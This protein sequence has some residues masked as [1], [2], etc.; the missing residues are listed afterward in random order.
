[1]EE[2]LAMAAICIMIGFFTVVLVLFGLGGAFIYKATVASKNTNHKYKKNKFTPIQRSTDPAILQP[3]PSPMAMLRIIP[4]QNVNPHTSPESIL[5]SNSKIISL[6][7]ELLTIP[8]K[9][10]KENAEL[11]KAVRAE[12][13]KNI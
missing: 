12:I 3:Q 13:K 5:H 11:L 4:I 1:M 2:S 7:E 8:D 9:L 10:Q 6:L